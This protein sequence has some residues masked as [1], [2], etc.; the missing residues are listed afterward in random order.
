MMDKTYWQKNSECNSKQYQHI[1]V[2][3]ELAAAPNLMKSNRITAGGQD[4]DTLR[5]LC[6]ERN[7]CRQ[8][9]HYVYQA[10]ECALHGAYVGATG[11]RVGT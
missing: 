3:I 5:K 11:D 2:K 6:F 7:A 1:Q 10:D 4:K 9:Q 8:K